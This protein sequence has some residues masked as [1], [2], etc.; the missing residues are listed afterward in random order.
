M[1]DF[2]VSRKLGLDRTIIQAGSFDHNTTKQDRDRILKKALEDDGSFFITRNNH[3]S[4]C[5]ED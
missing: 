5:L 4:Y 1:F 2:N 3:F